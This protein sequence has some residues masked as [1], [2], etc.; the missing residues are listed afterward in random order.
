[1]EE[2]A[3]EEIQ[4]IKEFIESFGYRTITQNFYDRWEI[5]AFTKDRSGRHPA[6]YTISI[7]GTVA[8]MCCWR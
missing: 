7:T 3:P 1:M 5:N 6:G 2:K 8:P 4:A